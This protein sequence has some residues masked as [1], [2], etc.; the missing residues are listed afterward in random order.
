MQ[1]SLKQT[2]DTILTLYWVQVQ[3]QYICNNERGVLDKKG[4]QIWGVYEKRCYHNI[5]Q[6]SLKKSFENPGY[7]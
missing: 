1:K 2:L 5:S 3:T 6:Q 7:H 4:F